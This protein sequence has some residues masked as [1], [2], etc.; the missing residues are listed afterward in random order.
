M[1]IGFGSAAARTIRS[2]R[3]PVYLP[4]ELTPEQEVKLDALEA[5]IEAARKD[6]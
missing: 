3:D 6:D 1:L 2:A 4:V 5:E